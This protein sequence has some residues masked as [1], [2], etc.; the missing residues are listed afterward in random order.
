[1][2]NKEKIERLTVGQEI[3]L[4]E[5]RDEWLKVGL[6]TLPADRPRAEAAISEMYAILEKPRP[7]FVWC[8][9]P[10]TAQVIMYL[11]PTIG[12][13]LERALGSSPRASLWE[14]LG[15]SL[16]VSLEESLGNSLG[17]SLR[18]SLRDSLG[19]SLGES[20]WGS[21][22]EG[23]GNSLSESL[24][25]I[26]GDSLRESLGDS[27]GDVLQDRLRDSTIPYVPTSMWGQMDAYWVAFYKFCAEVGV[28]Y[29]PEAERRLE[30]WAEISRSA[31]WWWPFE[32]AVVISERPSD[33]HMEPSRNRA[34]RLV[35][36]S[37]ESPAVTFR[38]GWAVYAIHGVLAPAYIVEQPE[39]ITAERVLA[40]PNAE[41][42]RV[43][44]DRMGEER[45]V[46]EAKPEV[47]DEDIDGGG[48]ERQLLRIALNGDEP[49]VAVRVSCPST[50]HRYLLRVPPDTRTA[51]QGVAWTFGYEGE[52]VIDYATLVEA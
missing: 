29:Q 38:D 28:T 11:W 37:L 31:G 46:A 47:L 33:I 26:L 15:D 35:L 27:L 41:V 6:S 49:F 5:F 51:L 4:A 25:E 24:W 23:L 2:A 48:Q 34:D 16:E 52:R 36:H 39:E 21:L 14:I 1:M 43:M 19:R 9:S 18:D 30:L 32:N 20:L 42:R 13:S 40:Q 3:R 22:G 45:F 17:E 44:I 8:D 12:D 7:R 50:G 10:L